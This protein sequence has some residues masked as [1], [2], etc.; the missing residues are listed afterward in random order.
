MEKKITKLGSEELLEVS[1]GRE[2]Y[3]KRSWAKKFDTVGI[4]NKEDHK[5]SK[6]SA[7][8]MHPKKEN[9]EVKLS[10]DI[11]VGDERGE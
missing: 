6:I 5:E 10:D 11:D 4:E 1:G 9:E 3:V 8:G 7:V 2:N